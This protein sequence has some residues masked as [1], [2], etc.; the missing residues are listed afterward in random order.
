MHQF[1]HRLLL[2]SDASSSSTRN[3]VPTTVNSAEPV[4]AVGSVGGTTPI[5][6]ARSVA[7]AIGFTHS[8]AMP[9]VY[10]K[11]NL[12]ARAGILHEPWG[13]VNDRH[14]EVMFCTVLCWPLH[15]RIHM[16][17]SPSHVCTCVCVCAYPHVCVRICV[18]AHTYICTAW[19]VRTLAH[20]RRWPSQGSTVR[21]V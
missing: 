15:A 8:F 1:V 21:Q 5:G 12:T 20:A 14:R 11:H 4:S 13:G 9:P 10:R 16:Y 18:C 6:K 19:I 3:A 7:K 2:L 17:V